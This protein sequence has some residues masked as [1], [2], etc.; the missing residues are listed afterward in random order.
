MLKI[1]THSVS[2]LRRR[3]AQQ[4]CGRTVLAALAAR[5]ACGFRTQPRPFGPWG[6]THHELARARDERDVHTANQTRTSPNLGRDLLHDGVELLVC[7]AL[8]VPR[9]RELRVNELS[10]DVHLERAGCSTVHVL[11][12]SDLSRKLLL[13][14]SFQCGRELRIASAAS[15]LNTNGY[16]RDRCRLWKALRKVRSFT[17]HCA[18]REQSASWAEAAEAAIAGG[19]A[20]ARG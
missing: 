12:D 13:Q 17:A 19:L 10:V 1:P 2:G 6:C 18:S 3:R 7:L 5:H 16:H 11:A 15:V 8:P 20:A 14:K 4:A 9:H